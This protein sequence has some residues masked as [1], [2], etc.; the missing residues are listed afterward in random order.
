MSLIRLLAVAALLAFAVAAPSQGQQK[1]WLVGTWKG[2]LGGLS[3]TNQYG[4][5]RILTVNSVAADGTASGVWEGSSTKQGVKLT[6]AGDNVT[7][8]TPGAQGAT[9][10]MTHKGNA[11]EGSWQGSGSGRSGPITLSKQ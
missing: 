1:H 6:V 7:F 3:T 10:K 8:T 4:A 5:D 9:Y 2:A 11:L